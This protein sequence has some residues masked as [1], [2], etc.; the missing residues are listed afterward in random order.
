M[1]THRIKAETQKCLEQEIRVEAWGGAPAQTL[2]RLLRRCT[3]AL[4]MPHDGALRVATPL[5]QHRHVRVLPPL[6]SHTA[7]LVS[8]GM[9]DRSKRVVDTAA[10]CVNT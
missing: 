7:R 5:Q 4:L 1:S 8:M 3:H 10:G 2:R 9:E 6:I